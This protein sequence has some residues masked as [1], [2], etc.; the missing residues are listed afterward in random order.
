MQCPDAGCG[1]HAYICTVCCIPKIHHILSIYICKERGWLDD[2]QKNFKKESIEYK[3]GWSNKSVG[4]FHVF[5]FF[6]D[7]LYINL[8]HTQYNIICKGTGLAYMQKE[9]ESVEEKK[10][11]E[12]LNQYGNTHK[13]STVYF[14]FMEIILEHKLWQTICNHKIYTPHLY[15]IIR[16]KVLWTYEIMAIWNDR[17]Q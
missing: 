10:K 4:Y 13:T 15:S 2:P 7:F 6:C 11:K 17:I 14:I 1:L 5:F 9:G 3:I 12:K 8:L 16:N